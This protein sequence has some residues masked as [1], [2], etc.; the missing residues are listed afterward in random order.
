MQPNPFSQTMVRMQL[1]ADAGTSISAR[2]FTLEADADRC[3]EV[4]KD[5]AEDL[6]SHGFTK[7]ADKAAVAKK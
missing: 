4:P 5:V 3:V 6:K 7:A 1:P 2:G